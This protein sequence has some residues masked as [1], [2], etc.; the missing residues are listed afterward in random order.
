MLTCG[1]Y[2]TAGLLLVLYYFTLIV[3]CIKNLILGLSF[4]LFDCFSPG[5][6]AES[7]HAG[8][9]STDLYEG[10]ELSEEDLN[11]LLAQEY[12]LKAHKGPLK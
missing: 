3:S 5:V 8:D 1:L 10:F 11:G 9:G 12:A 6:M 4:G 7:P 2:S